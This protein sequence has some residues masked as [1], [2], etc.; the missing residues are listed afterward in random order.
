MCTSLRISRSS[1][2]TRSPAISVC[3][4][5]SPNPSR[6]GYSATPAVAHEHV[7]VR[8]PALGVADRVGHDDEQP[9]R[10]P[11]RRATR[12]AP[13][14]SIRRGPATARRSPGPG[15]SATS[16]RNAGSDSNAARIPSS[17]IRS[18]GSE[19]PAATLVAPRASTTSISATR[20]PSA[21]SSRRACNGRCAEASKAR[22]APRRTHQR[23]RGRR[24]HAV[25]P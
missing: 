21:R 15:S 13:R 18:Q 10:Q 25:A 6:G 22:R 24:A 2:S 8:E 1:V 14:R 5:T 3:G 23:S 17:A 11:P 12:P 16:R 9:P 19:P 20:Q 7:Q 4:S